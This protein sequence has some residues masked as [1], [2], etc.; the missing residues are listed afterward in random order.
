MRPAVALLLFAAAASGQAVPLKPRTAPDAGKSVLVRQESRQEVDTRVRDAAGKELR[1][2]LVSTSE[3]A[4]YTLAVQEARGGVPVKFSH[5][6]T[7]ADETR[8]G[9]RAPLPWQGRKILFALAAGKLKAEAADGKAFPPVEASAVEKAASSR[10][11]DTLLPL[12]PGKDVSAGDEWEIAPSKAA[13]GLTLPLDEKASKASGKLLKV[14]DKEGV[15]FAIAEVQASLAVE[16]GKVEYKAR[17][18]AAVDG[19]STRGSYRLDLTLTGTREAD[20]K[21]RK[22]TVGGT[23]RRTVTLDV[24]EQAGK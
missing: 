15:R 8:D 2:R 9:R 10:F 21:G 22:L 4:E 18:D 13:I 17:I 1:R 19:K 5:A 16:G 23:T 7:R 6:Y 12:L 11:L 14:Y 20:E 24:G 3:V